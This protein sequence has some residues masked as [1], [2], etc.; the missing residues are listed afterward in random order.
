MRL[1]SICKA[2]CFCFTKKKKQFAYRPV[3]TDDQFDFEE[4]TG[5]EEK[6]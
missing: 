5:G 2:L 1:G 4:P 6:V 3:P